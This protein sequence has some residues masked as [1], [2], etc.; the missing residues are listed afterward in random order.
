MHPPHLQ[1][2]SK[3][4]NRVVIRLPEGWFVVARMPERYPR[5]VI[6]GWRCFDH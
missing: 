5:F 2:M 4:V 1:Q 6:L 3:E